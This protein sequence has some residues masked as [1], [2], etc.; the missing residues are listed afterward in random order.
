MI[1]FANVSFPSLHRDQVM[2]EGPDRGFMMGLDSLYEILE[3][4]LEE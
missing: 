3:S 2:H 1:D 4:L